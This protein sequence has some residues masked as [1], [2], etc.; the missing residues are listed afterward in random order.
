MAIDFPPALPPQLTTVAEISTTAGAS[1]PYIG[2]VNGYEL[3]KGH[4]LV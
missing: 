1:A 3:R 2:L 4:L